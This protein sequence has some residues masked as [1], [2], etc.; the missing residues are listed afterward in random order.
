MATI[1][2]E[3]RH[4]HCGVTQYSANATISRLAAAFPFVRRALGA[5]AAGSPRPPSPLGA[6]EADGFTL[7]ALYKYYLPASLPKGRRT[8]APRKY[9]FL[10]ARWCSCY[11]KKHEKQEK[12]G[13]EQ[14][15][16]K[17]KELHNKNQWWLMLIICGG[18]S[19]A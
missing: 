14:E 13:Y 9:S 12:E 7:I 4:C 3:S 18:K 10:G 15:K 17:K 16:K 19:V 8:G 6:Q 2:T 1:V 11:K 5:L